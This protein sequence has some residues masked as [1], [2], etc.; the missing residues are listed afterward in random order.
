[1]IKISSPTSENGLTQETI[2]ARG[3]VHSE[4]HL[5]IPAKIRNRLWLQ[6]QDDKVEYI[7]DRY[8]QKI[9]IRKKEEH[10]FPDD[11]GEVFKEVK[12]IQNR[13]LLLP[14]AIRNLL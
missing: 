3:R 1:M 5:T 6:H 8:N 9:Y 12:I 14:S 13:W 11:D 4:S 10:P 7:I 2:A